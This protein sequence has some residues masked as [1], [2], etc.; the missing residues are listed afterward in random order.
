MVIGLARWIR[1][2]GYEAH[3]PLPGSSD[4]SIAEFVIQKNL[5]LLTR[6]R[7]F[8]RRKDV[9]ANCLLLSSNDLEAWV[10][11]L[12]ENQVI[13]WQRA[14]M[15]R[16]FICNGTVQ[17]LPP[18]KIAAAT[19]QWQCESCLRI[20]WKGSHYNKILAQLR[21]WAIASQQ[22]DFKVRAQADGVR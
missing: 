6:D 3:T 2:A 8:S 5:M 18:R 21:R 13:N 1:A 22:A 4:Q 12:N 11:E 10:D 19:P 17:P 15:T 7:A 20:Y 9:R 16:C 14:P